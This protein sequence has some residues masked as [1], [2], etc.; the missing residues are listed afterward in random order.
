MQGVFE[1]RRY[2]FNGS[3]KPVQC[4]IRRSTVIRRKYLTV[5]EIESKNSEAEDRRDARLGK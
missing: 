3:V 5:H 4:Q 2:H 1:M